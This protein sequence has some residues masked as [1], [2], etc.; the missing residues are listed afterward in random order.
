MSCFSALPLTVFLSCV[1]ENLSRFLVSPPL[2]RPIEAHIYTHSEVRSNDYLTD[3]DTCL[4]TVRAL[5]TTP[6]LI[7]VDDQYSFDN[8]HA[9]Q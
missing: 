3:C 6:L 2:Y 4:N 9:P 1:N 5:R 8:C 7:G